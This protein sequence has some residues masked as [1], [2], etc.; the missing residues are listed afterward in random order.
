MSNTK[1]V[2]FEVEIEFLKEYDEWVRYHTKFPS[3]QAAII[4]GMK[5]QM[6]Q[7]EA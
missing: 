5:E 4:A 6:K 1:L 3:R 7:K 2:N